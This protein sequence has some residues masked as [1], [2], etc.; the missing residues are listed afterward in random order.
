M[1]RAPVGPLLR[2]LRFRSADNN[3]SSS[4]FCLCL[5]AQQRLQSYVAVGRK[6]RTDRL[7]WFNNKRC[8]SICCSIVWSL[9]LACVRQ[10]ATSF[11]KRAIF[12][13]NSARMLCWTVP[14]C[15]RCLAK[16]KRKQTDKHIYVNK[17]QT[18]RIFGRPLGCTQPLRHTSRS[19]WDSLAV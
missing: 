7:R 16:K 6:R 19:S 15:A 11:S 3:E 2:S 8:C 17:K 4:R 12:D 10:C 14:N 1:D 9:S 18:N 13:S 5:F